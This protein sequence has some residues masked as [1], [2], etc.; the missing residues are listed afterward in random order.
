M[1]R[2][3]KYILAGLVLTTAGLCFVLLATEPGLRLIWSRLQDA[4]PAGV[5]AESVSGRLIG[6]LRVRGFLLDAG[7]TRLHVESATIDWAPTGLFGGVVMIRTMTLDGVEVVSRQVEEDPAPFTLPDKLEWGWALSVDDLRASRI[8]IRPGA[9]S[10]PI[11]IDAIRL[12]G[13][14]G[15]TRLAIRRI[16]VLSPDAE[17]EGSGL[18]ETRG[19]YPVEA[20]FQWQARIEGYPPLAGRTRLD[21]SLRELNV[22][23]TLSAPWAVTADV[24][25]RDL[26]GDLSIEGRVS[27]AEVDPG[28]LGLDIPFRILDTDVEGEGRPND[29]GFRV[30][31]RLAHTTLGSAVADVDGRFRDGTLFLDSLQTGIPGQSARLSGKGEIN[32]ND[33]SPRIVASLE[34]ADLRWPP[35]GDAW[36]FSPGGRLSVAGG[37]TSYRLSGAGQLEP[38]GYP[39]AAF[40]LEGSG[41]RDSLRLD[42]LRLAALDGAIDGVGSLRW[43]PDLQA[44]IEISARDINPGS[45]LPAWPGRL[46]LQGRVSARQDQGRL[47][48]DVPGLQVTGRILDYPLRIDAGVH[49][50]PGALNVRSLLV[51]SGESRIEARGLVGENL[52]LSWSIESPDLGD[53]LP[54]A[55]GSLVASGTALGSLGEPLVTAA[56]QGDQ[57]A[58]RDAGARG[59]SVDARID[60]TGSSPSAVALELLE[61]R[62]S[63]IEVER[64]SL[65]GEGTPY[66]HALDFSAVTGLGTA[67]ISADGRFAQKGWDYRLTHATLAAGPLEPLT[68]RGDATGRIERNTARLDPS[69]WASGT[70]TLCMNGYRAE[71]GYGVDFTVESLQAAWFA[72]W[73]PPGLSVD[74]EISGTGHLAVSAGPEVEA[75][76][77]LTSGS[78]GI[79]MAT[80]DGE[81]LR[82]LAFDP[83]ELHLDLDGDGLRL[84]AALPLADTGGLVAEAAVGAGASPLFDRPLSGK[85]SADVRDIR[86]LSGLVPEVNQVE[87]RVEGSVLLAGTLRQPT[88]TGTL[89]LRE[90][91]A[92]LHRPGLTLRD[93]DIELA[94]QG[95]GTALIRMRARSGDGALEVS[96][97]AD[98]L[99]DPVR[100]ELDIVGDEV[101]VLD[102]PEARLFASPDLQLTMIGE[103]LKVSGQITVP[104]GSIEPKQLPTTAVSVSADQV[105]VDESE[106]QKPATPLE[107]DA[108]IR[109]LIKDKLKFSGFGLKGRFEGNLLLIDKPG[110][111]TEATGELRILDGTY[112]AYGQNL[113]IQTGRLL[114]AGGPVTEPGIDVEAVRRPESGVLVGIRARG[115]LKQPAFSL[116][117][118]PLM[119]ESDQLSYLVLGRPME[120]QATDEE[121]TAMNQAAMGLGLAG[122]AL[123]GEQIGEKLG[124]DELTVGSGPGETT[125]EQASLL[126]GKYLSPKLYV[127]YGL[128]LFEPVSTFRMR[129]LLS[130]RWVIIGETSALRSGADFFYVI[131]RGD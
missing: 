82:V 129:Y 10:R 30:R 7:S 73:L 108:R 70:A 78:G 80:D 115:E 130:S 63:G 31:A 38:Q 125:S 53:M 8:G 20:S 87:G 88:L 102:I 119:S 15:G 98:L 61:A 104:R 47:D 12:A 43:H 37:M 107:L 3:L 122:G 60:I 34:W 39:P 96:G 49:Y 71:S 100:V 26:F 105:I 6:P 126:V 90:G 94:G 45:W 86:V 5:G 41:D 35:A 85:L 120:R 66:D 55:A 111:P 14:F 29:L 25:V 32:L 64:V 113:D 99:A 92:R 58:Y 22:G 59:L 69:C 127:S 19:D 123:L 117:S 81:S 9:E 76:L 46:D 24:T 72:P 52:D 33:P 101:Q 18:L 28:D 75:N 93:L 97:T 50:L 128:G 65:T 1:R 121:R 11:R 48:L 4:L 84:S 110:R 57:L 54:D 62:A 74:S 109:L 124:V 131:E 27:A 23:Q 44:E 91:M 67:E 112:R 56:I 103:R 21:G 2:L 51:Q 68:L 83:G 116:F 79:S 17:L 95:S 118:E 106:T 114:F 42:H 13:R 40:E 16:S 77:H 36:L 89:A